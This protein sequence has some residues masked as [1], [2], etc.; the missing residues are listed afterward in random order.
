MLA[1]SSVAKAGIMPIMPERSDALAMSSS[2]E[3]LVIP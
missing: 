2:S 1:A 3:T